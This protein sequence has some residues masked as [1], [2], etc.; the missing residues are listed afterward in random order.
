MNLKGI[1]MNKQ[2][3]GMP[4][5]FDWKGYQEAIKNRWELTFE[6]SKITR[7]KKHDTLFLADSEDSCWACYQEFQGKES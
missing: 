6:E 7:C 3:E 1:K 5:P 2:P 4:F